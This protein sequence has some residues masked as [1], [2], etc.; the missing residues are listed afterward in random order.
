MC[1]GRTGRGAGR[2][3]K[4]RV[5]W[6]QRC[7]AREDTHGH[8]DQHEPVGVPCGQS[9]AVVGQAFEQRA[10]DGEAADKEGVRM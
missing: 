2:R 3:S 6:R 7:E 4:V 5:T 10:Q 8:F 9:F 1:R